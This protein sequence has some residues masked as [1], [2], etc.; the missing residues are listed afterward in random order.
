MAN[1]LRHIHTNTN[2]KNKQTN[3]EIHLTTVLGIV[4]RNIWEL[5]PSGTFSIFIFVFVCMSLFIFLSLQ[6]L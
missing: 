1:S 6:L 4:D 2:H 3:L 5:L